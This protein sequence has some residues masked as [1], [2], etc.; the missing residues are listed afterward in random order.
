MNVPA[1]APDLT[2]Y[3]V[4]LANSSGGY[5]GGWGLSTEANGLVSLRPPHDVPRTPPW[6]P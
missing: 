6:F 2:N 3:D 4:L 5:L 1:G